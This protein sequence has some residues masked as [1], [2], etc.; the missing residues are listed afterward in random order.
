MA[1]RGM[2]GTSVYR[3]RVGCGPGGYTVGGYMGGYGGGVIPGTQPLLEG[4]V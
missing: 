4:E 3:A 1:V 2:T